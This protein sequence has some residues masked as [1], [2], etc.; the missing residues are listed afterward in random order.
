M[1]T[2]CSFIHFQGSDASA[3]HFYFMR[4][5]GIRKDSGFMEET[6]GI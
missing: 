4:L 3:S 5:K 1:N 2:G 6:E